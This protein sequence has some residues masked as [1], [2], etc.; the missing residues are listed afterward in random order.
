MKNGFIFFSILFL[1]I[2]PVCGQKLEYTGYGGVM[3]H[4]P[5]NAG[6]GVYGAGLSARI[7][8][9]RPVPAT[10]KVQYLFGQLGYNY[11]LP[12]D[13]YRAFIPSAKLG[14]KRKLSG[15][16]R[17]DFHLLMGAGSQFWF[18]ET[19]IR[20]PDKTIN[21]SFYHTSPFIDAGVGLGI[22]NIYSLHLEYQYVFR[23]ENNQAHN[24][25]FLSLMLGF[26]F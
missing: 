1:A 9:A 21:E 8:A 17:K 13:G 19:S 11:L 14:Y 25:G 12:R 10:Q 22:N 26:K 15:K 24:T 18:E 3:V 6:L 23:K 4:F 2:Q 7:E 20:F 16:G 5:T